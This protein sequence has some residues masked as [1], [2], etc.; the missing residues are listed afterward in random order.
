MTLVLGIG[1]VIMMMYAIVILI[2]CCGGLCILLCCRERA[3][4]AFSVIDSPLAEKIPYI[5]ALKG[6]KKKSF[7]KVKK[8]NRTMD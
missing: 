6:L 4:G 7:S 8:E 1:Y 2:A 5:E 3:T